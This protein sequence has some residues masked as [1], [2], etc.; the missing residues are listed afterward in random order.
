MKHLGTAMLVVLTVFAYVCV[1]VERAYA[2]GVSQAFGGFVTIKATDGNCPNNAGPFTIKPA[3]NFFPKSYYFASPGRSVP[4]TG[5]WVL[6]LYDRVQDTSSCHKNDK[7]KSA[8]PTYK[9]T[10][11][12]RSGPLGGGSLVNTLVG[13]AAEEATTI[14]QGSGEEAGNTGDDADTGDT[15]GTGDSGGVPDVDDGE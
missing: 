4:S 3:G 2:F 6:G 14:I 5:Q 13:A 8:Y 11:F 1:S 15:D 12:G 10:L 9:V 7:N